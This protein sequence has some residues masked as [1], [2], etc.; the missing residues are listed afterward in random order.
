MSG[1]P[2]TEGETKHYQAIEFAR[3]AGVTVRTLHHYDRIGLLKPSGHTDAGYRLYRKHDLIRLQQIITLKFIGFSLN[4][5]KNLLNN[6]S[7]D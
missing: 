2:K 7:F 6:N 5:I 1:K 3:L 4:H